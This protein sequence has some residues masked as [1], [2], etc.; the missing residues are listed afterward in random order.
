MTEIEHPIRGRRYEGHLNEYY[1][2]QE[3]NGT[4]LGDIVKAQHPST[5]G[6]LVAIVRIVERDAPSDHIGVIR[7]PGRTMEN[8][9]ATEYGNI[10]GI[11]GYNRGTQGHN[12]RY[13]TSLYNGPCRKCVSNCK[14]EEM[15]AFYREEAK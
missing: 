2:I 14:G 4:R 3:Y 1:Y 12:F 9:Y 6:E 15:C 10:L 5:E 8:G 7:V 13:I 11:S